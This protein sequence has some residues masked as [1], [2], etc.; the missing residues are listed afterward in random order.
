[1]KTALDYVRAAAARVRVSGLGGTFP[2]VGLT[3][4]VLFLPDA[5]YARPEKP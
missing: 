1:M 2:F 3:A 4:L 5:R